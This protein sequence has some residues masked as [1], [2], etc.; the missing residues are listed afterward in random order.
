MCR[1]SVST[2]VRT[3]TSFSGE[4]NGAE[5]EEVLAGKG[6]RGLEGGASSLLLAKVR[7]GQQDAFHALLCQ[8]I[9]AN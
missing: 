5:T 9:I 1:A 8:K 7:S 2:S 4:D 6:H 3:T